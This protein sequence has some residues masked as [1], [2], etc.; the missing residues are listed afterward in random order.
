[1]RRYRAYCEAKGIVGS[2]Y[3][4]SA[5]TF[6]GPGE[7][8][9]EPWTVAVHQPDDDQHVMGP[10][11]YDAYCA[12]ESTRVLAAQAQRDAERAVALP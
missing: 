11:E 4:K 7:H 3:V 2:P 12:E 5:A 8:Y 1:M 10:A 6:F 9:A